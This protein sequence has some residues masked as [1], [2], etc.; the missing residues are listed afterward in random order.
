MLAAGETVGRGTAF[1]SHWALLQLEAFAVGALDL[2]G[3]GLMG[4]DLNGGQAAVVLL[5]QRPPGSLSAAGSLQE[6]GAAP[7]QWS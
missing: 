3:V 2:G 4:A 6:N 7:G 5:G 1:P